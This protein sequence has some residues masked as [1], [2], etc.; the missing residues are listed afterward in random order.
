M[1]RSEGGALDRSKVPMLWIDLDAGD[2]DLQGRRGGVGE[3]RRIKARFPCRGDGEESMREREAMVEMIRDGVERD[4]GD[5]QDS[6]ARC[7]F[8]R[9]CCI[10]YWAM[11]R[12][13]RAH[14]LHFRAMI[15]HLLEI[16]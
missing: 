9:R 11:Y 15:G 6:S 12:G 1:G 16:V 14:K 7:H 10:T 13:L 3:E 5:M 4:Y 2:A 8:W